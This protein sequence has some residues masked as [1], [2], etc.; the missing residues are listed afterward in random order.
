[1][2]GARQLTQLFRAEEEERA[3]RLRPT[4]LVAKMRERHPQCRSLFI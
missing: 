4:E 3:G 2:P 1:M